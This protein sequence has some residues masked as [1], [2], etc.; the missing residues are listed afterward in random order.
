MIRASGMQLLE[1][2]LG[3]LSRLSIQTVHKVLNRIINKIAQNN[4]MAIYFPNHN[5]FWMFAPW[6][7]KKVP[8]KE[9]ARTLGRQCF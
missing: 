3:C 7:V 8:S 2:Q 1:I 4:A 9:I 5:T 6:T